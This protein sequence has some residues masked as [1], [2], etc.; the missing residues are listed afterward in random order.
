MIS[1][2][3]KSYHIYTYKILTKVQRNINVYNEFD[4]L[5]LLQMNILTVIFHKCDNGLNTC[6]HTVT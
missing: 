5:V 6:R 1:L 2:P 3:T 4:E